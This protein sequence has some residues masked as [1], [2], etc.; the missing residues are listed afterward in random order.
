MEAH[1][2]WLRQIDAELEGELTLVEQAALARHLVSCS[3]CA[4][5]RASHLELRVAMARAA[6]EPHA[7]RVPRPS[8]RGRAVVVWAAL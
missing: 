2:D 3:H 8:I 1:T 6:G 7:R 4:G 5:A